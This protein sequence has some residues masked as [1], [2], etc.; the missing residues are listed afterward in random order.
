MTP[1]AAPF[2]IRPATPA[3]GERVAAMC[4]ALSAEE[5]TGNPSRFTA[6]AFRRDGFGPRPAFA[7]LI[8]ELNGQALGYALYHDDY[9]TDRLCRS[10]YLADLYVETAARGRG[11]GRALMAAV[12]QAGRR[13]DARG[14]MWS[15][16]KTNLAARGFYAAIGEEIDDQI[17]TLAAGPQFDALVAAA[18][19][20]DGI[21]LRT[22]TAADC[23]LLAHFLGS[24][25]AEIGL[26]QALEAAARFSADGFGPDPAFTAVIAEHA[27]VPAG[28]ALFWP[29]YD[30]EWATRG[31]WLS[32]LYMLPQARRHGIA[33]R[34][35]AEVAARTAAQGG[36]YLIWLV[37]AEN[38]RARAFYRT[39]GT[40][41]PDGIPCIC[42][43]EEFRALAASAAT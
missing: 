2:R 9:D 31:G 13:H 8:A 32:D 30:T 20:S 1:P 34:L 7:C 40:E 10:V 5:A 43:G 23:L 18:A 38:T 6:G 24:M 15:V 27:G 14:M 35:M 37:H 17:E 3:D 11:I 39:L 26:E 19:P 22:A 41:W 33:R 28:Y 25:L 12:A 42:A 36:R 21:A 29:T 16:L 4:A